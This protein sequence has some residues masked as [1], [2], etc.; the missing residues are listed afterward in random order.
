[1]GW[2]LPVPCL[3]SVFIRTVHKKTLWKDSTSSDPCLKTDQNIHQFRLSLFG[4]WECRHV[5]RE[6]PIRDPDWRIFG[7]PL[8]EERIP[9]AATAQ[10]AYSGERKFV[11]T[12]LSVACPDAL[13]GA[14]SDLPIL[15]SSLSGPSRPVELFIPELSD[16]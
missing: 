3:T 13:S 14:L 4:S 16:P 9:V 11:Q 6:S 7:Q 10:T 5:M 12:D 2:N 8:R 15:S 1:M